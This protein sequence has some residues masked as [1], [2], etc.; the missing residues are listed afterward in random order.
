MKFPPTDG[1]KSS[2]THWANELE[3][4][5]LFHLFAEAEQLKSNVRRILIKAEDWD[6]TYW[7]AQNAAKNAIVKR[8]YV[9]V[10]GH[11]RQ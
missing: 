11:F 10:L 1:K 4:P 7:L 5:T 9:L 2:A 8:L 3:Q 6:M